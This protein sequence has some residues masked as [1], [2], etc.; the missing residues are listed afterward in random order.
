MGDN[1]YKIHSLELAITIIWFRKFICPLCAGMH[2]IRYLVTSNRSNQIS[3][4]F[5]LEILIV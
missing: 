1:A 5:L 4:Y 2:I 3:S